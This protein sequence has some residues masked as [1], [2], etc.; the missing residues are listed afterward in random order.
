LNIGEL[1]EVQRLIDSG[2]DVRLGDYDRR[3]ALHIACSEG[4]HDVVKLLLQKGAQ[5]SVI[6]RWKNT[7]LDDAI[8]NG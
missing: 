7:P 5:V 2:V 1:S 6:D 8:S 4:H 3:T